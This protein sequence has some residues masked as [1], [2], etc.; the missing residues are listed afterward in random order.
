MCALRHNKHVSDGILA[1][2]FGAFILPV[3]T[4]LAD[5]QDL[6]AF[7]GSH[8][9]PFAITHIAVTAN[10]IQRGGNITAKGIEPC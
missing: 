2:I 7:P 1:D 5:A 10:T 6:R 3:G 8:A 9:D 4:S